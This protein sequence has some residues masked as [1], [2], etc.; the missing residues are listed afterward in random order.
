L[1][2]I[3]KLSERLGISQADVVEMAVRL[4]AEEK[5]PRPG[6]MDLAL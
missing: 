5:L 4:L 2:L 6:A 1:T 3:R